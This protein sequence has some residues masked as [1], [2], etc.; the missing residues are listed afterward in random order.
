MRLKSENIGFLVA[1]LLMLPV[2]SCNGENGPDDLGIA[3]NL[4][5][6][7]TASTQEPGK[8]SVQA[9]AN[10]AVNYELYILPNTTPFETNTSGSFLLAF[11]QTGT[12]EIQIR[13]FGSSGKFITGNRTFEVKLPV[14]VSL[15]YTTPLVYE[16]YNLVWNDEFAGSA[17]NHNNW[18]AEVGDGCP[19]LCGW[20]NNE[21]QF[22]RAQ[23]ATV[24]GGTLTIEA[25]RE[26]VQ[27]RNF[28]S[29]RIKTQG[30]KSFKYGRIDIRALLPVGQG[31]WPALWMLGNNITSVGWPRCGEIDI[32]E[33]IGGSGRERE[34]HGTVHWDNNGHSYIGGKYTLPSGIF[35]DQYHVFSIIWDETKIRWFVNDIRFYEIDITPEHMTEFHQQFFF[36]FN[37]AVGGNW[38]GSPNAATVFPQQMKV[39]YVR[40]FQKQN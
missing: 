39:D 8:V 15:G 3:S 37:V 28:T 18:V 21:L 22:Y 6:I 40:V 10:N 17:L 31:I 13:A 16:G 32:M 23:N 35:A 26:T 4:Q 38:P 27:S 12:Y 14:P 1:F 30:L 2:I 9:Q 24:S 5:I 20:G 25:R 34:V 33:M 19:N 36:I 11:T 29:A 7:I